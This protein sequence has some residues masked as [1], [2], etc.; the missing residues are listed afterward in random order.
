M[1]LPFSVIV[2][3]RIGAGAVSSYN[4]VPLIW[5]IVVK[6]KYYTILTWPV[7]WEISYY[8]KFHLVWSAGYWH[9]ALLPL[10]R[11]ARFLPTSWPV[12]QSS[13]EVTSKFHPFHLPWWRLTFLTLNRLI[14]QHAY[15]PAV[16]VFSR[17][18]VPLVRA[19]GMQCEIILH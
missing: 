3:G 1:P 2:K 12:Q 16:M 18:L 7:T 19:I 14:I 5:T 10:V 8:F 17:N 4:L 11:I 15:C 13:V 6:C 9:D